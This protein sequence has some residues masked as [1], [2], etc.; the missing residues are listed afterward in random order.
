MTIKLLISDDCCVQIS[1]LAYLLSLV[2][3]CLDSLQADFK[4]LQG[5]EGCF[6]PEVSHEYT[7]QPYKDVSSERFSFH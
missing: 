2:Y 6:G 7:G 1:I 4:L 5:Q 3:C